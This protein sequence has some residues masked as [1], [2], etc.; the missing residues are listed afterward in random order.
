[1]GK[2]SITI[3][4][5]CVLTPV[6]KVW[7]V[8]L[9]PLK[10]QRKQNFG[11]K[12]SL[13]W[14]VEWAHLIINVYITR[15]TLAPRRIMLLLLG[16]V[17]PERDVSSRLLATLPGVPVGDG[18]R[19]FEENMDSLR[20]EKFDA[21]FAGDI[22]YWDL[23]VR[24]LLSMLLLLPE[25]LW[26]RPWSPKVRVVEVKV[27]LGMTLWGGLIGSGRAILLLPCFRR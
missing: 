11:E 10:T 2:R 7:H 6:R 8:F 13:W 21:N 15:V 16:A 19:M 22:W 20:L 4:S 27:T 9:R 18:W 14:I 23:I 26:L 3:F 1:M 24:M 25:L 17:L 5:L 12:I